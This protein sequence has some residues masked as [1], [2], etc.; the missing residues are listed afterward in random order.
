MVRRVPLESGDVDLPEEAGGND[1]TVVVCMDARTG[2]EL[3][4]VVGKTIPVP[5]TGDYV[6]IGTIDSFETETV[7]DDGRPYVVEE[8]GIQYYYHRNQAQEF[9]G[10]TTIVYLM[11]AP[12]E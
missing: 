12:A 3:E 9:T 6:S 8:R 7:T 10:T 4:M 2:E 5:E 11:V 1:V